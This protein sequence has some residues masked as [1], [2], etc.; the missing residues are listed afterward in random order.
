MITT[1][2]G[3][4]TNIDQLVEKILRIMQ[5]E[6]LNP[7]EKDDLIV[8]LSERVSEEFLLSWLLWDSHEFCVDPVAFYVRMF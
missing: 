5:E 8:L 1:E 2:N 7:E 6:E 4:K 3:A